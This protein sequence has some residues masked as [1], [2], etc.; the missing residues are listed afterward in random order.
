MHP[1]PFTH[2]PPRYCASQLKNSE[3][4]YEWARSTSGL[5]KPKKTLEEKKGK[6]IYRRFFYFVPSKGTGAVDRSKLTKYT[7]VGTSRLH[8]F[9]DI[10]KVGT[11]STRRAACH[12]CD[13]CWDN[14]PRNC[15]NSAYV[16]PPTE[17]DLGLTGLGSG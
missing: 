1:T 10:G 16:G 5:A 7:A 6:G 14:K 11:V 12:Q 8:E 9:T 2:C 3:L 17:L 13:H 15:A 4:F